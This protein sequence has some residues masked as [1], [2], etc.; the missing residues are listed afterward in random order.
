MWRRELH[1]VIARLMYKCL[2]GGWKWYREV[3]K[4]VSP[5][6][7]CLVNRACLWKKTQKEKNPSRSACAWL[8]IELILV[9]AQ[10]NLRSYLHR[11]KSFKANTQ[12]LFLCNNQKISPS[13]S[14]YYIF[15]DNIFWDT[16]CTDKFHWLELMN[17]FLTFLKIFSYFFVFPLY[18]IKG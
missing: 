5:F 17:L 1:A 2:W 18:W 8:L 10:N 14:F 9:F 11:T 6:P 4:I 16:N 7:F 3:K 15:S 12:L 13:I